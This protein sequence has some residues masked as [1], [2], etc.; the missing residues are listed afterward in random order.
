[1]WS[2]LFGKNKENK[3]ETT[4]ISAEQTIEIIIND[5]AIAIQNCEKSLIEAQKNKDEITNTYFFHQEKSESLYQKA[6]QAMKNGNENQ[7]KKYLEDKNMADIATKNYQ[8]IYENATQNVKKLEVQ[9]LKMNT[10]LVEV[11][12]KKTILI[13]QLS[14]AQTQKEITQKL[15]SL[16]ISTDDF[17]NQI[18]YTQA[19]NFIQQDD[20][21]TK[22]NDLDSFNEQ[23]DI[24]K[25]DINQLEK[26]IEKENQQKKEQQIINQS[27][28]FQNFFEEKDKNKKNTT[29]KLEEKNKTKDT[30]ETFF[31]QEN[32]SKNEKIEEFFT[33]KNDD[34]DKKI[35]D[36]F[37]NNS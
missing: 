25:V 33:K 37:N 24:Q 34:K 10:Q 6:M 30:I 13:A 7:A 17:E 1:M 27:K 9:L 36:F 14:Q 19:E 35:N 12:T 5:I 20:L 26:E 11:K 3:T 8:S 18:T 22:I 4:E 28:K 16:Q 21:T 31:N 32:S 2:K 23:I 15:Q 29:E